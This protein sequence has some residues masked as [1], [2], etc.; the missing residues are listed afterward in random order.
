MN[1]LIKTTAALA[2][3]LS[4]AGIA[5]ANVKAEWPS[6][7]RVDQ[8]RDG[9]IDEQE[10]QSAQNL[11]DFNL[12]SADSNRDGKVNPSEYTTAMHLNNNP[13]DSIGAGSNAGSHG[14]GP[15][16]AGDSGSAGTTG[17]GGSS[18]NTATE[19]VPGYSR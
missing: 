5:H 2:V 6:F 12:R 1:S 3:S 16:N 10:A 11:S 18:G 14:S 4:L 13:E 15:G 9:F 19:S 7:N 17:A 8:N